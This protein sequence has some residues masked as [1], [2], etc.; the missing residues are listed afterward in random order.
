MEMADPPRLLKALL[1]QEVDR[2]MSL[3]I[4]QKAN[5]TTRTAPER[6][7]FHLARKSLPLIQATVN[8]KRTEKC[9]RVF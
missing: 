4:T 3:I 8:V 5:S 9:S 1:L 6:V 2:L 7:I